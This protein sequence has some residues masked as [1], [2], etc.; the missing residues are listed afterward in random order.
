MKIGDVPDNKASILAVLGDYHAFA[1]TVRA[2]KTYATQI[3][4]YSILLFLCLCIVAVWA[5]TELE[6]VDN[7]M[8]K[9]LIMQQGKTCK[10][11]MVYL[12]QL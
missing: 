6:A 11:G 3:S 8:K 7:H 10:A 12:L 9:F 2:N 1:N 5:G 4:N